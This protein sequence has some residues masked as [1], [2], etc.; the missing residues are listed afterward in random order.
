VQG[1]EG[2]DQRL[3]RPPPGGVV[4]ERLGVLDRVQYGPD[5]VAHDVERGLVDRWVGAQAD[6]PRHRHP[7]VA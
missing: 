6:H 4:T 2:I 3:T 7:G 1:D 5:D